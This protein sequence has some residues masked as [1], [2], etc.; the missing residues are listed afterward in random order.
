MRDRLGMYMKKV[1]LKIDNSSSFPGIAWG[2]GGSFMM[3]DESC[4]SL[5]GHDVD[6]QGQTQNLAFSDKLR[7]DKSLRQPHC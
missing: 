5:L 4:I 1:N 7:M 2:N 3:F 6:R